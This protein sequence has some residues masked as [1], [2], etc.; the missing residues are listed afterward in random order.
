MTR[1]RAVLSLAAAVA[2][3][4]LA[5]VPVVRAQDSGKPIAGVG[6]DPKDDPLV[7]PPSLTQPY[8]AAKATEDDWLIMTFD[9]SPKTVNGI[10]G[11]SHDESVVVTLLYDGPFTFDAKLE[12][13]INDYFAESFTLSDDKKTWT[14]KLKPGLKWH[15]GAPF[16][17]HDVVFS[18]DA[19]MD[20]QVMSVQK[21]G[22]DDL[23]SVT[24]VDDLTVKYV[25]KDPSPVSKWACNFVCIP[26]HLYEKGRKED[27]T[28]KASPYY[29]ELNRKGVGNGPYRL[30]EWKENDKLVFE[31]WEEWPGPKPHYKR[32]I[33]RIIPEQN[34]QLL[35]FEG[36]EVDEMELPAKF[37]AD[38]AVRSEKFKKVGYKALGQQWLYSYIGWNAD[39][40]NP[41]FNDVRVRKAMTHS[42]NIKLM[43]EKLCYNL[44][45][46]CYGIWHPS[47]PMSSK[48][49]KLLDF[50]LDKAATLLDEAG[51]EVSD[52][53]GWR[54]KNGTK[55]SFTLM[56][57]QGTSVSLEVAAIL[58]QDLKSLGV[59]MKTQVIEWATWQ[60]RSRKR[61]FQANIAAWG[62][63]AYPD[64][65]SNMWHSKYLQTEGGRNYTGFKNARVD[66]LFDKAITEFDEAKRMAM[67]AEIQK[68][69]YDEQPYTFLW[70]RPVLWAFN[71]RIR[72][73]TFSPRGVLTFDP[74]YFGWWTAKGE[75]AYGAK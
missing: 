48:D 13:K 47:A 15:D 43:I 33:A 21:Q 22:T 16:T 32:V 53:D 17:A 11:S 29:A 27:P 52:E 40:S 74:A 51:W 67:F 8:D 50:D 39:G 45:P 71:R 23:E 28:L 64:T 57:P 6:Y 25:V 19:I 41:F 38:A 55:F 54:Y 36:G 49:I 35:T 42:T 65:S 60:E 58:Q 56:I 5:A 2:A 70:N 20:P 75:Q 34:V 44:N 68:I 37:F 10:M 18:Y 61:E 12:F 9:G 4:A 31:R 3:A 59:E 7:N 62:T 63:G 30:V 72:G 66:E 69:I 26:K 46:Q 14:L 1:A 24:A 73:V